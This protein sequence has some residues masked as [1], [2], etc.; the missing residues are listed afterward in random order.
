MCTEPGRSA[1]AARHPSRA[2]GAAAFTVLE[3]L[4]VMAILAILLAILLPSLGAARRSADRVR[5]KAL[6]AQWVSAIEAFRRAYGTYPAFDA[7]GLVNGG[8]EV[9]DSGNHVFHDTLAGKRRDGGPLFSNSPAAAQNPRRIAFQQFADSD[10]DADGLLCDATRNVSIAVLVDRNLD[11]AIKV[12]GA[13]SDY[14][15]LPLVALPGGGVSAPVLGMGEGAF[16]SAGLRAGVAFYAAAPSAT[17]E[18]RDFVI[19]WK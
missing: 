3:L 16:P 9:G 6:F 12:G 4:T 14:D 17:A 7:S 1:R 19:S 2:R 18:S 5:T 10:F 11:G 13:V 8:V 15:A